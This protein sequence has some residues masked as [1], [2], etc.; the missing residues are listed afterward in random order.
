PRDRVAAHRPGTQG[1]LYGIHQDGMVL[2]LSGNGEEADVE[3]L[4]ATFGLE[5]ALAGEIG[6]ALDA[7][8]PTAAPF[9]RGAIAADGQMQQAVRGLPI[10]GGNEAGNGHVPIEEIDAQTFEPAAGAQPAQRLVGHDAI[11]VMNDAE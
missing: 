9:L 1:A 8:R 10:D 5:D 2:A 4:A 3:D 7:Y 11:A 6:E